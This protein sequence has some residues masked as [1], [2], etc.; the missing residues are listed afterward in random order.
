MT[1]RDKNRKVC[2]QIKS[3]VKGKCAPEKNEWRKL[4][5]SK[6]KIKRPFYNSHL[7]SL[8]KSKLNNREVMGFVKLGSIQKTSMERMKF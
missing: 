4:G 8:N 5:E 3:E 6:N 7:R 2:L 1:I